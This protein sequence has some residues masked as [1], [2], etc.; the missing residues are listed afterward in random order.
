[1]TRQVRTLVFGILLWGGIFTDAGWSNIQ[2]PFKGRIDF[3]EK[4]LLVTLNPQAS[5]PI[6]IIITQPED[7]VCQVVVNIENFSASLF[8]ISTVLESQ[9]RLIRKEDSP[10]TLNGKFASRYTLINH[11][12]VDELNGEFVI[13][14]K[15][16]LIKSLSI[17]R[18]VFGGGSFQLEKPQ[19]V[20]LQV[21]LSN[22]DME[23]FIAVLAGKNDLSVEGYLNGDVRIFGDPGRPQIRG[24][25]SSFGGRLKQGEFSSLL[26]NL[27][28]VFPELQVVDSFITKPG[29]LTFRLNGMIDLSDR[30]HM[31]RQIRLF[32]REPYVRSQDGNVE[33]TFKR[34][35]L[36]DNSGA[37]EFKYLFRSD[38]DIHSLSE[39]GTDML[40]FERKMEF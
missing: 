8:H 19:R 30:G 35:Q 26:L 6:V 18:N 25:L 16:L 17:G 3:P 15:K 13:Q 1:M 28:G 29:G 12:P 11:K 2:I 27:E 23:E 24:R 33:W 4:R 5:K 14:E 40:G 9:L 7:N 31:D 34:V 10:W 22:I 20:D 39:K 36:D 38:E 37:T 21:Q 32:H